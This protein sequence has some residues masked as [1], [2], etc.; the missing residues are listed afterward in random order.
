MDLQKIP[1]KLGLSDFPVGLG[2]CRI[3]ENYFD[4]CGYDVVV[5]DEKDEPEKIISIDDEMFVLHHGTFSETNSKKLLQYADLQ[6]I[7]DPSW[8]LR[9][10]LSKIKEKHSSLFADFAKNSLIESMFCCQKTKDSVDNSDD[11]APCWQ[12]CASFYLADAIASLNN[13]RLGPT[14]MLDSL[15]KFKKTP[16]NEH[17]SVVTQ[18]VGIERATPVLLERMVKSTIGFSDMVEKNSHSK[19]IQ[20]KHD[21]FVK[22]SMISDCYFYLGYVNKENFIKI[23]STLSRNHDLIHVL[24][25]AFDI[26][27]DSN[28]LLQQADLIQNS[29]NALLALE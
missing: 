13:K 17:I 12:K 28:V 18:T 11:F 14:H 1:E 26:E 27:A 10:F 29:C 6:I 9:M 8:E 23:K 24:K 25:T 2:G 4:S 7:Q 5:F 15:R 16:I 22:N 20:Q 19:I 21:Y 3:S